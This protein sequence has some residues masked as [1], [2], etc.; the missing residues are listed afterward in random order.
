MRACVAF[1]PGS[2]CWSAGREDRTGGS[3]DEAVEGIV[4]AVEAAHE[5]ESASSAIARAMR[6]VVVVCMARTVGATANGPA[7]RR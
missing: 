2:E 5:N 3:V 6:Y 4:A 7:T 1:A